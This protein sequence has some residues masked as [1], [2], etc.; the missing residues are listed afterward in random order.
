MEFSNITFV[1]EYL[2]FILFFFFYS[3]F[4]FKV[5]LGDGERRKKHESGS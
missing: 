3:F 4:F 1:L 2:I 5:D